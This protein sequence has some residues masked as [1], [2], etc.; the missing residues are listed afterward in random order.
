VTG[1]KYQA[2]A[3]QFEAHR[4]HLRAMAY[5]ML[6]AAGE[7]E[8]AV[9][10][11]W[12]RL[13]RQG[14]EGIHNLRAWLTTV[15]ARVCLDMLRARAARREQALEDT[16]A[17][18]AATRAPA[19]DPE[20]EALLA[21]SVGLALLMI[22][23]RLSPAERVAFI[24]HDT[25]AL[26]FEEIAAILGRTP[27]AARQLASR[28]RRAVRGAGAPSAARDEQRAVAQAFLA[29][30]RARDIPG[31]LAVLDPEVVVHADGAAAGGAARVIHGAA[32]WA[33]GA[34]AFAHMARFLSP[35][36]VDG[37]P[38]LMLAPRGRLQRVVR[39]TI[40]GGRITAAEIIAEP[41]RLQDLQVGVL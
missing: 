9:Q 31:L 20:Q 5:R 26:P 22:L 19:P 21:E 35:A 4:S 38:A 30:L 33:H 17:P 11:A 1:S 8:D 40:S 13:D 6:G 16:P 39:F 12:L 3:E 14:A 7:A 28:A 27:A 34:V 2:L 23:D 18:P 29:A 10:E 36:L 15:V 32:N 37:Q 24:L 41:A 25:F